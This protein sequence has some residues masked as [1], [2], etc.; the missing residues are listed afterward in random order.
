MLGLLRRILLMDGHDRDSQRV[1]I[2]IVRRNAW[3]IAAPAARGVHWWRAHGG[4]EAHT[5]VRSINAGML[6]IMTHWHVDDLL[7]RFIAC[8]YRG[9]GRAARLAA[10]RGASIKRRLHG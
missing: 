9:A 3:I 2:T 6:I 10:P 8:R 1:I 4:G 5:A 7:G